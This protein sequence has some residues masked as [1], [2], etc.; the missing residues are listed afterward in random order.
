MT[1]KKTILYIEDDPAST[2]MLNMLLENYPDISLLTSWSAEEGLILADKN[3]P[4]L[5]FID[6]N[7]PRMNGN[8]AIT[9]LKANK[10]LQHAKMV[11]IS[12]NVKINQIDQ[13]MQ[14][15]FDGYLTK[16]VDLSKI[17]EL[18]ESL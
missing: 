12:S 13:S 2:E 10:N 15:G 9:E 14:C 7:L 17:I 8:E 18:I 11:A 6:I 16:P 5:I 4:D 3:R 1:S